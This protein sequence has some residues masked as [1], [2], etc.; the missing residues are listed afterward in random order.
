MIR[1]TS[2]RREDGFEIS[3]DAARLDVDAVHNWLSN[4]SYWARGR[5]FDVVERSIVNSLNFGVYDAGGT[6]VGFARVVTD[7][8]TFGWLC[9]VYIDKS[10][11]GHGL[12]SW[13]VTVIRDHL[14]ALGLKRVILA[15][16]D[17]HEVYAK[18]GFKPLDEPARYMVANPQEP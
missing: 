14:A 4:E 10:Q 2:S 15:T 3:T 17:A 5:A 9:D 1:M 8:A 16:A 18:V 12:G 13:M 7:S 6:Q 11:R